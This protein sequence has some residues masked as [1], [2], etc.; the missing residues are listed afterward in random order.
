LTDKTLSGLWPSDH[1]S[2]IADLTYD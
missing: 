2:V 1:A